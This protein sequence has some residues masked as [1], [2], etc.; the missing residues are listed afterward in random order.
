MSIGKSI[1]FGMTVSEKNPI[2]TDDKVHLSYSYSFVKHV[3]TP[4]HITTKIVK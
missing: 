4:Q 2:S 3:D 1:L